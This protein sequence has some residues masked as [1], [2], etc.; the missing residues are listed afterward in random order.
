MAETNEKAV[1]KDDL[2]KI[3]ND[4]AVRI[5]IIPDG[6]DKIYIDNDAKAKDN[7]S[8]AYVLIG[9][10]LVGIIFV[11]LSM[12]KVIPF[13]IGNPYMYFGCLSAL[14]ILFIV[15]GGVSFINGRKFERASKGEK[16]LK[17]SLIEWSDNNLTRDSVDSLIADKDNYTEEEL[18]FKRNNVIRKLINRQFVN[19]DP[20]MVEN[21]I[22]T[23]I[24]DRIYGE[25]TD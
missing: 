10:G 23:V 25:E 15:M 14:F 13:R 12:F 17:D 24:Y 3:N 20:L 5:S 21:L 6:G 8:S 9:V 16:S 11:L 19:I 4:N 18:F 22:D 7:K 1:N 2:T